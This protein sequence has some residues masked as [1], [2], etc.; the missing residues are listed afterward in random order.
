MQTFIGSL[1]S[2]RSRYGIQNSMRVV[3]IPGLGSYDLTTGQTGWASVKQYVKSPWAFACMQ[4]RSSELANLPWR[5]TRN[6]VVIEKHPIID[7]LIQFGQESNYVESVQ[8]TEIDLLILGKGFWLRDADILQRLNANTITVK[9]DRTGI[10]EFTQIIDGKVVNRFAR[11]EVVYFREFNP[12]KDL[13]PGV[14]VL[15]VVKGAVAIEYESGLYAEAFFKNDATPSLLLT[16]DQTVAE[17]EMNRVKAWWDATFK[18]SKKAHKVAFADKGLKATVLSTSMKDIALVTI[19]DQARN[20]ICAGF[21][22]P[23]ILVGAMEEATYAN[24][25]E[26]RR[27]MLE[28][29]IIP[30]SKYFADVINAELVRKIDPSVTFEFVPQDLQILQEGANEKWKRLSDA[31][32]QGAISLPFAR[33][34][35]GWPEAAAPAEVP[36]PAPAPATTPE[37]AEMRAWRRKAARA[38]G[39]GKGADVPFECFSIDPARQAAIRAKLP[40]AGL[41]DLDGIFGQAESGALRTIVDLPAI[42]IEVKVPE[43]VPPVIHVTTPEVHVA[44]PEIHVQP[45]AVTVNVPKPP[46]IS[47]T[48]E[49]QEVERSKRDGFLTGTKKQTSYIYEDDDGDSNG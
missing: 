25:Q 18:G 35:M 14:P 17:S 33:A 12:A 30:R 10:Q 38:L 3:D 42:N 1:I 16:T 2:P 37:Q 20:D 19:R 22:V 15:E 39:A 29:V 46:K 27:F 4:I 28:D 43:Q 23:K 47:G 48:I 13:E 40:A 26:A 9:A 34:Q 49:T 44:A 11:D 32:T 21:R 45:P 41:D 8:A 6:G 24:A 7:M 31:V 5:L 36:K